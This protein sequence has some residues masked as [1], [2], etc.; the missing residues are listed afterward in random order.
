M[1]HDKT[2]N[3]AKGKWRGILLTLGL[4]EACLK[5]RH[6]PC[7]LC[8]GSDRFR[9]D[10]N[11]GKGTYI[12]GQC[13]AG[14]GMK[15][16]IEYTGKPFA[17]VARIIDGM[18]GNLKAEVPRQ[19]MTDEARREALRDTYRATVAV[20]EG[21][22]VHRYLT[23]RG[24]EDLIYPDALRFAARLRDGEGGIRPA[25]VAMIHGPDGEK[26]VSMHR[27]FLRPDGSG[28]AEM[29]APRKMMPGELPDGACV[30][31]SDYVPG[32]PLGIAEGIETA[33]SASALY[34]LPVW[35]AINSA[36]LKKWWPP[37]GCHEVAIFGDNDP[38]FGGQAAAWSLAH[39]LAVK[40]I[41]V[42]VHIPDEPG[43]D[44][45]DVHLARIHA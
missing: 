1:F 40:G 44:W 15:L 32:G 29:E 37:E 20:S 33:L 23:A 35:S 31:L 9:W 22:L 2:A 43:T 26:P 7:P 10:N 45:N 13:G 30:R 5:D 14:D 39:R 4:P 16:A 3:A 36:I 34:Q 12:C 17:E 28:K 27:T 8:G 11:E 25:M 41:A 19:P 6:G 38:K 21:D 18:V 42:T 24:V